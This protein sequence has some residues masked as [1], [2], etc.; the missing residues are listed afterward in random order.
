MDV[1]ITG[2]DGFV[3]QH[4]CSELIDR[5]HDVTSL[6]RTPDPSVLPDEVTLTQGDVTDYDSIE[7]AFEGKDVV[8]NLAALP[9]LHQPPRETSHDSVCIG[10]SI[11]A[12]EAAEEHGVTKFI[13]MS[14]LGADPNGEIAYWRTQGLGEEVVRCS[15]LDWIIFRPSFIFG[16]GSETFT[17][18]KQYTTPYITVLPD[19]GKTPKFQP[20]WVGD[21]VKM[22]ADGVES[23][24]H[25]GEVYELAGPEVLTFAEVTRLLYKA[26]GKS[27]EI[28]PVPMLIATITLYAL[29]PIPQIPLGINQ[30][31]A[32]QLTNVA[33]RNDIGR[34]GFD[35]SD[36][37]EL[38]TYLAGEQNGSEQQQMAAS[39]P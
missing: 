34:F 7:G 5:G 11:N 1:L 38:S 3:G 17:F 29:D 10:G 20:I 13:E 30:A 14:S 21:C 22:F 12:V 27:V 33:D 16:E 2:G 35:K 8:V 39:T 36:L 25:V 31:R 6:S 23:D 18:I 15:D 37:T 26:D 19:G 24:D 9:P 28:V 32:L 4:L